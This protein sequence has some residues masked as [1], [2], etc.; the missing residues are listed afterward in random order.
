MDPSFLSAKRQAALIRKGKE[1]DHDHLRRISQIMDTLN[2]DAETNRGA[3]DDP[4]AKAVRLAEQKQQLE[5]KLRERLEADF[6][7]LEELRKELKELGPK[8]DRE[9]SFVAGQRKQLTRRSNVIVEKIAAERE[10]IMTAMRRA[11]K[12]GG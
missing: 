10:R 5:N 9:D 1:L 8:K 7:E 3:S 11:P 4:A 6:V 2:R 12:T